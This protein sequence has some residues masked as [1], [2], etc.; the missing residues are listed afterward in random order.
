M[1][2]HARFCVASSAD[3]QKLAAAADPGGMTGGIWTWQATPAPKLSI[4]MS[5]NTLALNWTVPSLPFSLQQSP[6]LTPTNWVT[7]TNTP[8]LNYTNLQYQ[9]FLAAPANRCNFRLISTQQ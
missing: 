9:V 8:I 6:D 4:T 1:D 3:G 2:S 5:S 7:L